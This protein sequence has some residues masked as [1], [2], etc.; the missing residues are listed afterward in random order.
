MRIRDVVCGHS[1]T[2]LEGEFDRRYLVEDG[3]YL[4]GMDGEFN[5]GK[6]RG[7]QALLNQRVARLGPTAGHVDIGYLARFLPSALKKIEDETPYVTV[8]H[9]SAKLLRAIEVPLPPLDE[10]RRIAAILDR[11]DHLSDLAQRR[12]ASIRRVPSAIFAAM[13]LGKKSETLELAEVVQPGTIVTYGIVQAGPEYEGGIPYIRTGDIQD[14]QITLHNLRRTSPAIAEKFGRSTV[15]TGD[16]VMSI[17]A[18][19]GTT[20]V[21]PPEL[22][23]ANL[24]Q[25]TA[26]ISPSEVA[27]G[28]YLLEYLRSDEAQRWIQ[29]QVKGA[30]FREI[31]L[32]RLRRLPVPIAA[33]EAQEVFARRVRANDHC[34]KM[35]ISAA[36]SLEE[37]FASLESRAFSGQL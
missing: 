9:L 21:V 29:A 13:F 2:Y 35:A 25:G 31:T 17:R 18:T 33:A 23:G 28:P 24:T 27:T 8:K 26:R 20:A 22:D 32:G 3:D 19:V 36:N 10:Q 37:L 15:R 34:L 7:G 11:A 30:T 14:G 6:W 5:L 12:I 16:I 1:D 4:I